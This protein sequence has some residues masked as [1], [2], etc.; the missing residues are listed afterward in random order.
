VL[1]TLVAKLDSKGTAQATIAAVV[2]AVAVVAVL[3]Y[4]ANKLR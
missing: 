3:I 2:V 4:A 1:S